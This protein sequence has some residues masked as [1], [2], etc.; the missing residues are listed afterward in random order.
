M[1]ALLRVTGMR[2]N[3][4]CARTRFWLRADFSRDICSLLFPALFAE[5]AHLGLVSFGAIDVD[6]QVLE[7][8][9]QLFE[10]LRL[11]L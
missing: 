9:D 1:K 10:V 5:D 6:G 7:V 2:H 11:D 4:G 8:I 3:C